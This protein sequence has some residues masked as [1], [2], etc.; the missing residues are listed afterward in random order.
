MQICQRLKEL[1]KEKEFSQ[2]AVA[3]VLGIIYQQYARYEN[4]ERELPIRHAVTLARFYGVTLDYLVGL[5]DE[6]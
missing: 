1:R 4:G 5:T 6:R 2:K 3:E